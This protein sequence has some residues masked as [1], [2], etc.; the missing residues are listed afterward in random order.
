MS[1]KPSDQPTVTKKQGR[2]FLARWRRVNDFQNQELRARTPDEDVDAFCVVAETAAALGLTRTEQDEKES[3]QAR[4]R[5][6][7]LRRHYLGKEERPGRE[8]N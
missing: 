2:E 5:W 4:E 6:D 8:T 7:R 1:K 3:R